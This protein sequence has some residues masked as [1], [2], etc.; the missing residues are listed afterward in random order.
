MRKTSEER[1]W[2]KVDRSGD[3]WEWQPK[4]R[5]SYG[6]GAFRLSKEAGGGL[7][8]AHRFSYELAYGP[9]PEG[10]SVLHSCD[11]PPCV[12]PAHLRAGTKAE[13]AADRIARGRAVSWKKGPPAKCSSGHEDWYYPPNGGARRCRVCMRKKREEWKA[14][15]PHYYRDWSRAKRAKG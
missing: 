9:I 13:N 14:K 4:S 3:C 10:Q 2:A 1:F 8:S 5:T 12:N 6:Y 15:N 7:A 11:N